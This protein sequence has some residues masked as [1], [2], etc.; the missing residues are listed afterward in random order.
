MK[1]FIAA[2]L[3]LIF[4]LSLALSAF[5]DVSTELSYELNSNYYEISVP[6]TLSLNS[7]SA[8]LN[9]KMTENHTGS[10]VNV[11]ITGTYSTA[12]AGWR[13]LNGTNVSMD[14]SVGFDLM[15][16]DTAIAP[17]AIVPVG[18]F[19]VKLNVIV[20]SSELRFAPNGTYKEKL[21]FSL[22]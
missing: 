18:V 6:S 14:D 10:N 20:N 21:T 19:G 9:I 3:L 1:K 13:L 7:G 8:E 2:A 15:W 22:S 16:G 12:G 5:G 4:A 17:G 11:Q